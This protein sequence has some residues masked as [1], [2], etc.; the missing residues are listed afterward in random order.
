MKSPIKGNYTLHGIVVGCAAKTC[1]VKCA[2]QS[3]EIRLSSSLSFEELNSLL[4]LIV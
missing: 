2:V 4:Q 3:L 1:G